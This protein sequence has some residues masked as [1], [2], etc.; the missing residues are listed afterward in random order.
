MTTTTHAILL[1]ASLALGMLPGC[2]KDTASSGVGSSQTDA[3]ENDAR[4]GDAALEPSR[5]SDAGE[6]R[7]LPEAG[8]P[9]RDGGTPET[10]AG[11]AAHGGASAPRAGEPQAGSEAP[12]EPPDEP[13]AASD[14]D[15]GAVDPE[16][17]CA[18]CGGCEEVIEVVST[19]HTTNPV[20]YRDP[21]PTSGPHNPCWGH[22]D[23][24][25]DAPLPAERWVHNLEH[26]GV[27]FLYNCPDGCEPEVARLRELHR[28]R[29]RTIVTA[30]A[31]LPTRFGVV[32]WG[33]RLL[34]EC[35]DEA[36]LLAFYARNFDHAPESLDTPPN[37]NCPP[38]VP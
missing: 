11:N 19:M 6:R 36:A 37:P 29:P 7:A 24:Y 13:I 34:S 14:D 10:Q 22:W 26:G 21:P 30:Y 25:D 31:D 18:A 8:A 4:D 17:M 9:E 38:S 33:H 15:A 3:G 23:V 27:V 12:N 5:L 32:S 1:G 28:T 20:T 35:F 2:A 16:I